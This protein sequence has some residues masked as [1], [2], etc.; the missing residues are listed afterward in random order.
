MLLTSP[1]PQKHHWLC[2]A[3]QEIDLAF[4][5]APLL[6]V[7][8]IF[9][10]SGNES[11][12]MFSRQDQWQ[13]PSDVYGCRDKH[14][15]WRCELDLFHTTEDIFIQPLIHNF[16][17]GETDHPELSKAP[18]VARHPFFNHWI[19]SLLGWE[20]TFL[21]IFMQPIM[22]SWPPSSSGETLLPWSE[23]VTPPAKGFSLYGVINT[24]HFHKW[25]LILFEIALLRAR[26]T[27]SDCCRE[28]A[29]IGRENTLEG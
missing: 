13:R 21:Y 4:S 17:P 8:S 29:R 26:G 3:C 25:A 20:K 15:L 16:A 24:W 11:V 2:F 10:A 12:A 19:T 27:F 18:P 14:H 28:E 7:V 22:Y 6:K 23:S 1:S 5:S 9:S